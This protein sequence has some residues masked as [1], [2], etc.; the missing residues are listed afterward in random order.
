MSFRQHSVG[1]VQRLRN[2]QEN[3]SLN[4][5]LR[6]SVPTNRAQIAKSEGFGGDLACL[7]LAQA[8]NPRRAGGRFYFLEEPNTKKL[9]EK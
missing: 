9:S 3:N 6:P 7:P 1:W 8:G 2:I 5:S 4:R